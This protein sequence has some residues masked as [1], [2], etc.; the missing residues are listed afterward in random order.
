MSSRHEIGLQF[1]G[2]SSTVSMEVTPENQSQYQVMPCQHV[3][4][5]MFDILGHKSF[6]MI[7]W[8][9]WVYVL[10]REYMESL[11]NFISHFGASHDFH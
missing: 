6:I 5:M 8:E 10:K 7:V 3:L 4:M 1:Q 11:L 9:L 2:G